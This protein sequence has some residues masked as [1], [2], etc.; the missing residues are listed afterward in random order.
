MTAIY[1]T[2]EGVHYHTDELKRKEKC[3]FCG[4]LGEIPH[5]ADYI[6]G[7]LPH[8]SGEGAN[9][10]RGSIC[11]ECLTEGVNEDKLNEVIGSEEELKQEEVELA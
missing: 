2:D 7:T 5:K 9:S 3:D 10:D 8:I 6:D 1:E 4:K 11:R